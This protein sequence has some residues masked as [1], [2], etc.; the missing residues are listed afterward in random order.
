MGFTYA[1]SQDPREYWKQGYSSERDFIF[2]TTASLNYDALKALSHDV[3]DDNSLL[4]CCKAFRAK[5]GD[6][7]NLTVKK[8]PQAV[9]DNCQWGVDDY[10]LKIAPLSTPRTGAGPCRRSDER[11]GGRRGETQA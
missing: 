9:L 10:S 1:P 11:S 4:I 2:T 3:G 6:F 8:I 5:V 7:K